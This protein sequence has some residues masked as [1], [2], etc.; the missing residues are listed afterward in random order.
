MNRMSK[1][2]T[3]ERP[4]DRGRPQAKL[5][6]FANPNKKFLGRLRGIIK[7]VGDIESPV[8]PPKHGK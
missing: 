8:E 4:K 3:S 7:I 6:P 2:K 5:V 1:K